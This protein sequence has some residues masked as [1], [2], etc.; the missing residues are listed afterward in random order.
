MA[1][2]IV[3]N[4]EGDTPETRPRTG[5]LQEFVRFVMYSD[6]VIRQW[7]LREQQNTLSVVSWWARRLRATVG[8]MERQG[9]I[10]SRI[11]LVDEL[12]ILRDA[13][14]EVMTAGEG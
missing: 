12:L 1:I 11:Q 5:P 4:S 6:R 10:S 7:F 13:L 14:R 9:L 8:R 3:A 2:E